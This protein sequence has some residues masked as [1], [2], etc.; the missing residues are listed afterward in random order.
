[1]KPMDSKL[2]TTDWLLERIA[3]GALPPGQLEDARARLLTEPDGAARLA[4]LEADNRA[5]LA[6]HPPGEFAA[7]VQRRVH[8]AGVREAHGQRERSRGTLWVGLPLAAALG[9]ALL[10]T[11]APDQTA[12]LPGMEETLAL[13]GMDGERSKG[14]G[15]RLLVHRKGAGAEPQLL[16]DASLAR[17]GDVLQLSY[18]AEGMAYGAILSVDGRGAVTQHLP[19]SGAT[20]ATL[21]RAGTV[22]LPFA[23]ELDDAPDFEQF[24]FVTSSEPF[25]L[26]EVRAALQEAARA[27][28]TTPSLPAGLEA[29]TFLLHKPSP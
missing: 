29:R 27:P 23:Y 14:S 6:R 9:L 3:L 20:A 18:R 8:L 5:T 7:E 11:T 19:E 10:I 13:Q 17:P 25:S 1:M 22:P 21:E 12:P 4:A 24:L 16:E 2:R 26:E 28:G 15:P